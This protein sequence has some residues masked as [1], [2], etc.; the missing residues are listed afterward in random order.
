MKITAST[1]AA[2]TLTAAAA[3]AASDLPGGM[4]AGELLYES[5]MANRESVEG[6]RMEG[7]GEVAFEDGWMHMQSPNEK[8]L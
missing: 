7:R 5:S 3:V 2:C 4:S 1:A 6:W 8:M